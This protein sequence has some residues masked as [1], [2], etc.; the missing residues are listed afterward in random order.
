MSQFQKFLHEI[1]YTPRAYTGRGMFGRECIGIV[2][3]NAVVSAFDIGQQIQDSSS[4]DGYRIKGTV[5][6][7]SFGMNEIL[8]WPSEPYTSSSDVKK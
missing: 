4:M 2:I 3:P 7:D 6:S 5:Y 8:Y 1:G